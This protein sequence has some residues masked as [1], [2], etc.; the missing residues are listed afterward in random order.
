MKKLLGFVLFILGALI[1]VN[2]AIEPLIEPGML[3]S[4]NKIIAAYPD[5]RPFKYEDVYLTSRNGR[6]INGWFFK[7]ERS[8]KAILYLHG[9]SDNIGA[10][11]TLYT[12]RTF[13]RLP[14]NVFAID[15]QGYGKSEGAPSEEN[16]YNDAEAAYAF[17]E[18]KGF[19]PR[20]IIVVGNSMGGA[21]ATYLASKHEIG[22]LV[23]QRTFASIAEMAVRKNPLYRFPIIWFRSSYNTLEMIKKVKAPVLIVHSKQD[24]VVPYAMGVEIFKNCPGQK[25]LITIETGR[26]DDDIF[27]QEYIQS[28]KAMLK[29]K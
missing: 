20:G 10:P 9:N 22:G 3:Y 24:D 4:P 6:K 23:L 8:Q 26:H 14:A 12:I 15:Y 5:A 27:N 17:L 1:F 21:V 7:N 18:K 11:L 29:N 25:K 16:V 19:A 28:F 2:L 13:Y